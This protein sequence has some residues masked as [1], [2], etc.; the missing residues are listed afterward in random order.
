[1]RTYF[2]LG[3]WGG[4]CYKEDQVKSSILDLIII[5]I[6][7]FALQILLLAPNVSFFLDFL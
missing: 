7:I 2:W 3:E 1:M 5:T 4:I 6:K